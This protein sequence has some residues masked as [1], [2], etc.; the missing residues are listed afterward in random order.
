MLL[1]ASRPA[2]V[3][4]EQLRGLSGRLCTWRGYCFAGAYDLHL[5]RLASIAGRGADAERHLRAAIGVH[6]ELGAR[7]W[8]ARSREALADVLVAEGSEAEAG[9]LRTLAV[10]ELGTLGLPPAAT[11]A[12]A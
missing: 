3:L 1:R 2:A 7:A 6:D 4:Y 9:A 8:A 12:A 11:L 10:R 5:G